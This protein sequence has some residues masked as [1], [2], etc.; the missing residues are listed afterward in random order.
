MFLKALFWN[1]YF[2]TFLLMIIFLISSKL[3]MLVNYA[4]GS[5]KAANIKNI[6]TPF[7]HDFAILPHWFYKT[8]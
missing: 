2:S 5:T 6:M 8:M 3:R 1:R 7:N 4:A